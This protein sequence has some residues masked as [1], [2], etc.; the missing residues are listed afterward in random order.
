MSGSSKHIREQRILS[1]I[2]EE[3]QATTVSAKRMLMSVRNRTASST[4]LKQSWEE[5][6]GVE[7]RAKTDHRRLFIGL[8]LLTKMTAVG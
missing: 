6:T 8:V 1:E 4:D 3:K 5:S 7:V 2:K